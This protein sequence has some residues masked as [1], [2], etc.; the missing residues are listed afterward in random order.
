MPGRQVCKRWPST[1]SD[2]D[3]ARVERKAVAYGAV[4]LAKKQPA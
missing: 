4:L 3:Y 2:T 1:V